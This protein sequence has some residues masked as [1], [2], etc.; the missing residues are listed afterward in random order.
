MRG[1]LNLSF[2]IPLICETAGS[3]LALLIWPTVSCSRSLK[4]FINCWLLAVIRSET[5][6]LEIDMA[7]STA[8]ARENRVN[9]INGALNWAGSEA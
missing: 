5:S 4:E 6:S 3:S 8:K 7:N 9:E 2:F 1:S